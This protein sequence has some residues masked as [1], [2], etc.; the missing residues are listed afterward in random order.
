MTQ[1]ALEQLIVA[2]HQRLENLLERASQ[3]EERSPTLENSTTLLQEAIAELT[4]TLEELQ[5]VAEELQLQNEELTATHESLAAERH[6]YQDLFNFAPN[7]YLVTDVAGLIQEA[8]DAAAQLLH[9]EQCFLVGK[10]FSVFVHP[11]ERQKLR[12]IK[13]QLQQ[14][15]SIQRQELRM[16]YAEGTI[17]F[18][19]EIAAA[20]MRD[21]GGNLI[22]FRWMMRNFNT[23]KQTREALQVSE[24]KLSAILE[25]AIAVIASVRIFPNRDWEYEYMSSGSE[26]LFGYTPE[27]MQAQK[28]LWISRIVP[29]DLNACLTPLLADIFTECPVTVEYRFKHKDGKQRWIST[30]FRSRRDET[31]DCWIV[32]V[33]A[34]D[35]SDRKHLELALQASETKLN[36]I[37]N[38]AIAAIVCFRVFADR[39]WEY[40]Y[41]SC[42]SEAVF[43]FTPA[44]L[45]ADKMLWRSRVFPE[46]LEMVLM[47][48]YEGVFAERTTT[49]EYRVCHK[50]GSV[51]W[52][53]ATYS[54]RRDEAADCWIVTGVGQ[55]ISVQ[56]AALHEC[57]EAELAV[58]ESEA[59]YRTICELTSDYIYSC[60]VTPEGTI[61]D[62]WTTPNVSRITGYTYEELPKGENGWLNLIYP[63][64]FPALSRFIAQLLATHQ[65]GE[66]EYRIITQQ[67][68]V[69]WICDRIHPIW[70]ETQG[71]VVRLLG[72]VEDITGRKQAEA[73]LRKSE[74]HLRL[75]LDLTHIGSWDW[76]MITGELI[77]NDNH[78]R[79]LGLVPGKIQ[80]S[81]QVW[82]GRVHPEDIDRIEQARLQALETHTDYEAE[83]RT[84]H[85]DGSIRWLQARG[86]GLYDAEGQAV[87]MLGVLFDIS[88]RKQTEIALQQSEARF[89]Q[90]AET[91]D[92]V[93]YIATPGCSQMLYISPAYEKN[94][95]SQL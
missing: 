49:I 70:D 34:T 64:D 87:R 46:D 18:T 14:E 41:M 88:D 2:A 76:N 73:A 52:I 82:R 43:D 3:V 93:F 38:S 59:R 19:A 51:R 5:V 63:D 31:A 80:P 48:L 57:Q 16:F 86:R 75:A 66:L 35:I 45:M 83:Y 10:P 65:S 12:Q 68:Q 20:A 33:V 32:T 29:E 28:S 77:W 69:R 36:D 85:P 21:R 92:E 1:E 40:E 7:S 84:I 55:D 72:A 13:L 17:D 74:E 42:G 44:E 89:R 6:R 67:G 47:R 94:L 27:E 26:V 58:Q 11:G 50:D 79:L 15:G 90:L 4:D 39:D 25:N 8:N 62:E 56:Q 95:G 30:T 24:A 61:Q 91:I 37:L 22:G 78:Y 71:Q 9:V 81:Y 60:S 53:S 23:C 54:S